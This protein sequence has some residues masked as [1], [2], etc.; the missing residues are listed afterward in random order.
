VGP[1][2]NL[3]GCTKS[4]LPPPGIDTRTFYPVASSYTDFA[5]PAHKIIYTESVI[6]EHFGGTGGMTLETETRIPRE[7]HVSLPLCPS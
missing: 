6:D 2:D 4:R 3:D 7:N 1:R 5:I